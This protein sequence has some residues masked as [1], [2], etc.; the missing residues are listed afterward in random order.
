MQIRDRSRLPQRAAHCT[1]FCSLA[2]ACLRPSDKTRSKAFSLAAWTVVTRAAASVLPHDEKRSVRRPSVSAV[3]WL[4]NLQILKPLNTVMW[5]PIFYRWLPFLKFTYAYSLILHERNDMFDMKACVPALMMHNPIEI[6]PE[7]IVDT[8]YDLS[9]TR[10]GLPQGELK[11]CF[12]SDIHCCV[13]HGEPE[14]IMEILHE[15]E[16]DLV[17]C[18]GDCVDAD[19]YAARR[20][21]QGQSDDVYA[22]QWENQ[23]HP[24]DANAEQRENQNHSDNVYTAWRGYDNHLDDMAALLNRIAAE[25]PLYLALGNHETR[26]RAQRE[27]FGDRYDDFIDSL[28][29]DNIT[30]LDNRNAETDIRGIPVRIYGFTMRSK[31]YARLHHVEMPPVELRE[32]LGVPDPEAVNILLAHNPACRNACVKWGADLTLSGHYHGGIMRVGKHRGAVTPDFRIFSPNAY[33]WFENGGKHVIITSGAG[34]HTIPVRIANPR[35]IVSITLH[36]RGGHM[37]H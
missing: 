29:T 17:L 22:A 35:E 6:F 19:V 5:H 31:Y 30:I 20:G 24:D 37:N 34:E 15:E 27:R 11:I 10:P 16:P 1:F 36:V 9:I 25:Y 7:N 8:S 33:G 23:T 2:R 14:R 13:T 3:N 4:R 28:H 12:F 18:G 26:M 32:A 21:N